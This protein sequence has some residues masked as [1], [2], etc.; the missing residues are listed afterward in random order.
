MN[1]KYSRSD[2]I[3]AVKKPR[4]AIDQVRKLIDESLYIG[5]N[6][7][8]FDITHSE[9]IDV[10]NQDWDNL[11]ILDACR[12]DYFNQN[13]EIEGS[14]NK[15]ISKGGKSWPFMIENFVGRELHDTI[16]VTANLHAEKLSDDIFYTVETIPASR[17][18][19]EKVVEATKRIHKQ[20]PNKRLIIHFMQP[21]RPYLG[22]TAEELRQQL[23]NNLLSHTESVM[24]E[25]KKH[26]KPKIRFKVFRY[27]EYSHKYLHKMYEENLKIVLEHTYEL[28]ESLDGKSV[29]TSDHGELLGERKGLTQRRMYGH[30]NL[31]TSEGWTVPWFTIESE[32]RRDIIAEEPIG[33]ERLSEDVVKTRLRE[34]GYLD[35]EI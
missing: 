29:I 14:L 17:R 4:L 20:Y 1:S 18:N 7:S 26:I 23:N 19:P 25:E 28:L 34:L 11:I 12:Y 31:K 35:T 27:G 5:V 2:L 15:V 10:I 16:Y 24:G 13:I 9:G 21:H 30:K 33:F 6:N 3:K 32:N 22:P 8:R